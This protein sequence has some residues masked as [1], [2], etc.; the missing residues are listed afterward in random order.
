MLLMS[1]RT[2]I[3]TIHLALSI[4]FGLTAAWALTKDP[5]P[6]SFGHYALLFAPA[7][8]GFWT[9]KTIPDATVPSTMIWPFLAVGL[10]ILLLI[11]SA[12]VFAGEASSWMIVGAATSAAIYLRSA[13]GERTI[14]RS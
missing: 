7:V 14:G 6:P 2:R 9:G 1:E 13:L 4:A 8:L 10:I 5:T 12:L 11:T 3:R